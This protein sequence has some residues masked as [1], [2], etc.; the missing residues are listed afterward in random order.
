MK[1]IEQCLDEA[2]F[3]DLGETFEQVRTRIDCGT[4]TA[5]TLTDIVKEAME[6]HAKQCCESQKE[7]CALMVPGNMVYKE[8]R[9]DLHHIIL[10]TPN[11]AEKP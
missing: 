8:Y 4:V 5:N 9:E 6:I 2:S 1:T 11:V 7:H 10:S 3:K